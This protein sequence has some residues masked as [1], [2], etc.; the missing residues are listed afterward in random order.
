M[1]HNNKEVLDYWN[2]DEVESMYDKHLIT[3][4]IQLIKS[5]LK[6]NSKILDVGCGEGEGT[7][8]YSK[9]KN[10]TIIAADFSDTRLAKAKKRLEGMQNV[11][12]RKIDFLKK[13][14]IASDF[15]FI[16]SQRFLINLMDWELQ[17]KVLQELTNHL[18]PGGLLL[19]LEGSEDGV[20]E[21]NEF[22]A[23]FGLEPIQVK[24]HNLFLQKDK[25]E[26]FLRENK[27]KLIDKDGLGDYFL[28]T[29]GIRP[30]FDKELSWDNT[31]NKIASSTDLKMELKLK[32]RYS[33]LVLWVI[34]K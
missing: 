7:L 3:A 25:V 17:K 16:I 20:N 21:L 18:K 13:Y 22:R 10:S 9:T 32:D 33:R 4:E 6:E 34:Q 31:F 23:K 15:D 1:I 19:L 29:R 30:Y 28:L 12:F 8:E 2:K 11:K 26:E 27:L 5:K 24:W 14:K